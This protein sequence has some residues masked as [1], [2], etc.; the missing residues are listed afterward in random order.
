MITPQ[1]PTQ[2]SARAHLRALAHR[3]GIPAR[4]PDEDLETVGPASVAGRRAGSHSLGMTQR[5]RHPDT[6]A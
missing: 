5:R 2:R 4:R 1:G 3:N 6:G